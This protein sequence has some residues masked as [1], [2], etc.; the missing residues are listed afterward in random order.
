MSHNAHAHSHY[1]RGHGMQAEVEV[2]VHK[3]IHVRAFAHYTCETM[4]LRRCCSGDSNATIATLNCPQNFNLNRVLVTRESLNRLCG[5]GGAPLSRYL[6]DQVC[7]AVIG[8]I[9]KI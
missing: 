7:K 3:Y 5:Y 8:I 4:D 9:N 1:L 6:D 2:C